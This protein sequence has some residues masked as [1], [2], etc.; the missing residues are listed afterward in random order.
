MFSSASVTCL[1]LEFNI[2]TIYSQSI[3][4][5]TAFCSSTSVSFHSSLQDSSRQPIMPQAQ[6]I[7]IVSSRWSLSGNIFLPPWPALP[8]LLFYLSIPTRSIFLQNCISQLSSILIA[9]CFSVQ[10][11]EPYKSTLHIRVSTS[12]FFRFSFKFLD[13]ITSLLLKAAFT[14]AIQVLCPFHLFL[15]H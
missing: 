15:C 14:C 11:S 9:I 7:F 2:G 12:P 13:N 1:L 6:S 3:W 8:H 5:E 4:G 10:V